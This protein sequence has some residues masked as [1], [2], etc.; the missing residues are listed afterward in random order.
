[1]ITITASADKIGALLDRNIADVLRQ[2]DRTW[3]VL[4]VANE[5]D[6][7]SEWAWDRFVTLDSANGGLATL[8]FDGTWEDLV[9]AYHESRQG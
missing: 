7:V 5:T 3:N 4:T 1:M 8:D 2:E 9:E 6:I